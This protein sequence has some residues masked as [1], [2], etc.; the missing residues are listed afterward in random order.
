MS[1]GTAVP[2]SPKRLPAQDRRALVQSAS[3]ALNSAA[4]LEA[5]DGDPAVEEGRSVLGALAAGFAR[6][7]Q[8]P[9]EDSAEEG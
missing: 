5:V 6:L 9:G 8:A 1:S 7:A 4:R 3:A 2:F